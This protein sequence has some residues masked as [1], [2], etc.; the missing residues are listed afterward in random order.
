MHGQMP[1]LMYAFM[2]LAEL[3]TLRYIC[4][5]DDHR[6][7]EFIVVFFYTSEPCTHSPFL[8]AS[9]PVKGPCEQV[10]AYIC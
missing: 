10:S 4:F 7:I 6:N 9:R 5:D 8:W 3:W 2:L 1:T